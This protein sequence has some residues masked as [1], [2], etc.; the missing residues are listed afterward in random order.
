MSLL[1]SLRQ[2]R[3]EPEV[4]D[5]PDLDRWRHFQALGGLRRINAWCRV[6]STLWPAIRD[7]ARSRGAVRLLDVATGG[8]DI[9]LRL[10]HRAHRAGLKL[11][12]EGCD[13]SPAAIEYAQAQA[14]QQQAAV[15]FFRHD[16]LESDIPAGYDIITC[17]LWL[18]HLNE[19]QATDLLR[20][21]AGA[22]GQLLL[23]NDL[24]RG[25]TGLLLAYLGTRL[26]SRSAVVHSDGPQSVMAA[27]TLPEVQQLARQAGLEGAS[28]A[29]RWPCRFLL[30]WRRP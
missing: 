14:R 22:A 30:T 4:M 27:F 16:V 21:M 26:L 2:R 12:V 9:P 24:L 7:L 8:G 5:N 6:A 19:A 20:R 3:L 23:V 29:R 1:A 10:W 25:R 11:Q 13:V 28:L 18:H 15:Q 17:T